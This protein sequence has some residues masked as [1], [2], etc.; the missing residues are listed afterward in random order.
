[1][2]S[3]EGSLSDS[4]SK[5]ELICRNDQLG[6]GLAAHAVDGPG[7]ASTNGIG[8]TAG[9]FRDDSNR[10]IGAAH[11]GALVI[12]GI[13]AAEANDEAGVL[14]GAGESDGGANFDAE[15]FVGLGT[16]NVRS[17]GGVLFA[18]PRRM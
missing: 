2:V 9:L 12:E 10:A 8:V 15:G 7:S 13:G 5:R 11:D 16:R 18:A 14:R 3:F 17:R 1:M 6:V 4:I